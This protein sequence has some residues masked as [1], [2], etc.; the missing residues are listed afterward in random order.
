MA[1]LLLAAILAALL[2]GC[3]S[4]PAGRVAALP[5]DC[6]SAGT[7]EYASFAKAS[8]SS[9]YVYG[10]YLPPCF[11]AQADEAYPLLYLIP[12][13]GGGRRDWF[14]AGAAAVADDLI[15]TGELPPFI[16]VTSQD[17]GADLDAGNVT[18]ELMPFIERTYPVSPERRYRAVAGLSAG[19][20]AAYHIGLRFP[21]RFAAV[22]IFG[23]GLVQD[24]EAGV[25][26]WLSRPEPPRFFLNSCFSDPLGTV[27]MARAMI[28]LLDEAGAAHTHIFLPGYHD[29]DCWAPNLPAFFHWLALGW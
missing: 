4:S 17:V 26:A 1:R 12:G 21:E 22:G 29:F 7:V 2:A 25:R 27:E 18:G 10:L 13:A 15:L 23:M 16:I 11:E 8:D 9:H 5:A 28:G 14:E 3:G 20:I 24:D 19:G 6:D